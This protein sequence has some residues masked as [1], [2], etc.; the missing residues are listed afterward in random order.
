MN[1]KFNL[2]N[3]FKYWFDNKMSKGSLGFIRVLI[4]ASV[5]LA[6]IIAGLIILFN[7]NEEGEVAS[8]FWDSISTIINAC[9]P[10][11]ADGSLGYLILM[12]IVAIAGVLFTSVLMLSI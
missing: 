12:S 9:M 10:S 2:K 5:L 7:F 1:K 8:I 3:K 4:I 11:F 6:V